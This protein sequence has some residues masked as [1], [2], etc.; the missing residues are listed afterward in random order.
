MLVFAG[1]GNSYLW[2]LASLVTV[3]NDDCHLNLLRFAGLTDWQWC[4]EWGQ[5]LGE[6]SLFGCIT[7]NWL[8]ECWF[9]CFSRLCNTCV[10]VLNS[11]KL[12]TCEPGMTWHDWHDSYFSCHLLSL[13]WLEWWWVSAVPE[14]F[15]NAWFGYYYSL[16]CWLFQGLGNS[17]LWALHSLVTVLNDEWHFDLSAW[18]WHD[19]QIRLWLFKPWVFTG[20]QTDSDVITRMLFACRLTMQRRSL[21]GQEKSHWFIIS[22][23]K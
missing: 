14:W 15:Q 6:F 8:T 9:R 17:Y 12:W 13:C 23:V 11:L 16:W 10:W 21:R 5:L 3:T 19:S 7:T 22:G 18:A 4:G 2:A 1:L 20:W